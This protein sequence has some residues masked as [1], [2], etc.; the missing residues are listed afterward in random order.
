MPSFRLRRSLCSTR[1]EYVSRYITRIESYTT[2]KLQSRGDCKGTT[3]CRVCCYVVEGALVRARE[4]RRI[5]WDA[6]ASETI[7]L[8]SKVT[9]VGLIFGVFSACCFGGVQR[10]LEPFRQGES[11]LHP[12]IV[13]T[14]RRSKAAR[15]G[16]KLICIPSNFVRAQ[17]LFCPNR[18]EFRLQPYLLSSISSVL[19]EVPLWFAWQLHHVASSGWAFMLSVSIDCCRCWLLQVD[20]IIMICYVIYSHQ[21]GT[22]KTSNYTRR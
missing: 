5:L 19:R 12:K 6:Y 22:R 15:C 14:D 20:Y 4:N 18:M 1:T 21:P 9:P 17:I 3:F 7:S 13:S 11:L 8:S 10:D 2:C 16:D